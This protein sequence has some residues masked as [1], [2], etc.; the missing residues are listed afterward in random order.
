[1]LGIHM[2]PGH[3]T[4]QSCPGCLTTRVGFFSMW[5]LNAMGL[6]SGTWRRYL[7]GR[8]DSLVF[9]FPSLE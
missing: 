2:R 8:Q 6:Y 7:R 4:G 3:S 5:L 9:L 1:M